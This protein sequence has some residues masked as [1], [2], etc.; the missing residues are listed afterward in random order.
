MHRDLNQQITTQ[1]P[2]RV[3]T[4]KFGLTQQSSPFR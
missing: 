3:K 2:G 4:K 1:G